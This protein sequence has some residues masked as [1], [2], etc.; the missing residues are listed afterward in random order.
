[1][2]LGLIIL[3]FSS[4]IIGYSGA[5]MPGPVLIVTINEATKKG[6]KSGFYVPI[7]HAF[8][9]LILVILL[10]LGLAEVLFLKPIVALIGLLGGM[11]LSWMAYNTFK[12]VLK[13]KINL[14]LNAK[15]NNY[16]IGSMALGI[17][18]S[19]SNPFWLIWWVSVGAVFLLKSIEFGII[20][21]IAFYLGHILADLSWYGSVSFAVARGKNLISERVYQS[22]LIFC[23]A[24]LVF[25]GIFFIKFGLEALL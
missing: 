21:V 7:G 4:L 19:L 10:T 14:S 22:I 24:I 25:F 20:G 5:L 9:E 13:R 3:F 23:G 8:L 15:S 2:L 11:F 18:T 6:L 12:D 1:M 17:L 16:K